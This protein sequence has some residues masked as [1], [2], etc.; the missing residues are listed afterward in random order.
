VRARAVENLSHVIGVNRTGEGGGLGYD[1][2]SAAWS[3]WGEPLP[4]VATDPVV[5]EVDPTTV[6]SVRKKYPFLEDMQLLL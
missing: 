4:P 5:V 6:A 1:G 3:P 2:G